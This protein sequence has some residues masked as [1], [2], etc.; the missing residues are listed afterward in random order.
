[1]TSTIWKVYLQYPKIIKFEKNLNHFTN[2]NL[3]CKTWIL[4][5][6]IGTFPAEIYM[7]KEPQKLF[8]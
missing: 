2:S 3:L 7:H 4:Q 5:Y 8:K 6:N 1:M